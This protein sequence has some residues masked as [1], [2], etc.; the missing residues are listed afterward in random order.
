MRYIRYG[1]D[2][3]ATLVT[4][5]DRLGDKGFYIQPTIFSDVQVSCDCI[6]VP[7]QNFCLLQDMLSVPLETKKDIFKVRYMAVT[8]RHED[9]SG[10]DIWACAVDPQ[11]QV[12]I[13]LLSAI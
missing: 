6:Q 10:G 9:C 11:V 8:G 13:I 7:V 3:G 2:G 1:V 5:G 4:G 12:S